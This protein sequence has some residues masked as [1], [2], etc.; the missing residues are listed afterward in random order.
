MSRSAGSLA[1]VTGAAGGLGVAITHGLV[2]L[3][4][5]VLAVDRD[6]DRLEALAAD[7]GVGS[8]VPLIVDVTDSAAVTA[9]VQEAGTSMGP[10]LVLVNNAG[11][12]DRAARLMDMTD[13]LWHQEMAV[14]AAASFYLTRCC[15]GFMQEARWGRIVNI[16]SIA[17]SMG[18]YG[19][20]GYAA[21]KAAVIGLTKS[22]ALEAAR[23]GIT[24]NAVLPGIIQTPAFDRISPE[25]RDRVIAKTALRRAGT[26]EEVASLVSYLVTEA[27]GFLTGAELAV[28]GGQ[29]L[30]VF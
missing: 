18:D 10:P 12:T 1:V 17:A 24:A 4:H 3:G 9:G 15:L 30:F 29:G 21:S 25:V 2:S 14:H 11:I 16:S 8:V 27:A 20:A 22:T 6:R 28:D 7:V 26:A 13:E 5:R 23:F 19:H